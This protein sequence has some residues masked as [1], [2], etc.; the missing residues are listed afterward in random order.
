ME[1]NLI[2]IFFLLNNELVRIFI[3]YKTEKSAPDYLDVMAVLAE[4]R[5]PFAGTQ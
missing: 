5:W 2:P 4:K 3:L 1:Q